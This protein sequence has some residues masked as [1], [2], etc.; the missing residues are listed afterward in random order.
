MPKIVD[1]DQYRRELLGKS[2]DLF[3]QKGYAAITMRQIA[4]GLGVSTGTLYH[5]FPSKEA[6]FE[7]L[8][9]EMAQQDILRVATQLKNAQTLTERIEAA[10]DF[11]FK[12]RDYF[13]KQT[14]IYTDFYQQQS[15]EGSKRSDVLKQIGSRVRQAIAELL[16]IPDPYIASFVLSLIDGV[17]LG[18]LYGDEETAFKAQA[19][20][21]SQM[22]TAYLE[23]KPS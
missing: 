11:V 12:N 21:L 20:L 8:V 17:I 14:L 23:S 7:Q 15:R 6:L 9:E 19:K 3:A 4:Q 13:F 2:F 22:L 18:Q 10:F 16:G 5:Y 1:H